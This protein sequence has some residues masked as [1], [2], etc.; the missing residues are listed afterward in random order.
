MHVCFCVLTY[1]CVSA[2]DWR[3]EESFGVEVPGSGEML[4]MGTGD[5]T[6]FLC[7]SIYV[8]NFQGLSA[9]PYVEIFNIIGFVEIARSNL[10]KKKN[11]KSPILQFNI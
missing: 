8:L 9:A 2:S 4:Y 1:V 5:Q 11:R 7:K 6:Q 3:P 10:K